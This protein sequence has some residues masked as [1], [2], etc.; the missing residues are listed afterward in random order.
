MPPVELP[1]QAADAPAFDGEDPPFTVAYQYAGERIEEVF[2]T[3]FGGFG[4]GRVEL[5]HGDGRHVTLASDE[6]VEVR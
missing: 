6:V 4:N 1:D 5:H 3:A 2:E